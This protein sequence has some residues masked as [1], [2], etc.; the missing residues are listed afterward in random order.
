MGLARLLLLLGLDDCFNNGVKRLAR[1][2]TFGGGD[3]GCGRGGKGKV[4][5]GGVIRWN[6]RRLLKNRLGLFLD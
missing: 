5:N 3:N 1:D 2:I 6:G 4:S